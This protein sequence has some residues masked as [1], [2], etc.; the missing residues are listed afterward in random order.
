MDELTQALKT[1]EGGKFDFLRLYGVALDLSQEE[2]V[3]T[4]LYPESMSEITDEQRKQIED[5]V[6]S[7]VELSSRI[8]VKFKKSFLDKRLLR[9]DLLAY[10]TKNFRAIAAELSEEQIEIKKEPQKTTIVLHMNRLVKDYYESRLVKLK[11]LEFLENNFLGNFEIVAEESENYQ[12]QDEIAPIKYQI[13]AKKNP[14]YEVTPI[15]KLFGKDIAPFPEQIKNNTKPK[16][17]VILFGKI[18]KV[19]IKTFTAKKGK[20]AGQEKQYASF[21]L[22]DE[23]QIECIYFSTKTNQPK[24]A[25]L[26]DGLSFLCLGDIKLGLSGRMTYYISAMTLAQIKTPPHEDEE[27]IFYKTPVVLAEDYHEN[28]QENLFVKDPTYKEPIASRDIVVYDLE[29]TGLN[30]EICEII[31]IGAI[32]IE[33]GKIT[34]KFSTFVKP[35]QPI[36][37]EASR[38]NHITNDMVAN[39]PKIE[40]VIVDFYNFC[41]GCII[42]GYNNTDFDNKFLR[43]AYQKVGLTLQNENLDVLLIA[44]SKHLKTSNSKLTTVAAALGIDLSGAH[45]AYN[46]AFATAKVLLKLSEEG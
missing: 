26:Q 29:T 34:K 45:R 5:F 11:L 15:K 21:V 42:S 20:Q 24:L 27:A 36:P 35:T 16:T 2:C 32:K 30:P 9:R 13:E 17:S 37:E 4:F 18:S 40:D 39:A 3:F 10:L 46:D 6:K 7:R 8:R 25:A 38:I 14:R 33:K 12:I 28:R 23:K 1:F 22:D 41:K 19:E 44:R 43:K 31:E